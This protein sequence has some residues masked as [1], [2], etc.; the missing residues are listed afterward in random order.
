MINILLETDVLPS[1][2]IVY[3]VFLLYFISLNCIKGI[4]YQLQLVIIYYGTEVL[5]IAD[6]LTTNG[7]NSLTK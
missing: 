4:L 2:Q 5:L 3:Q 6:D 1:N 7:F